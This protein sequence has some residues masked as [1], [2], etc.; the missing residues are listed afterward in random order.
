MAAI[1]LH[2]RGAEGDDLQEICRIAD[3]SRATFYRA[4]RQYEEE[5]AVHI[6]KSKKR[7]RPREY[8][9]AD[10]MYL[11]SLVMRTPTYYLRDFQKKLS[12][13]RFLDLSESTLHRIFKRESF[14]HKKAEKRAAEQDEE[15]VARFIYSIS[16]Y[17]TAQLSYLDESAK[18]ERTYFKLY[19]RAP[20]GMPVEVEAPFVRGDRYT[21]LP[22]MDAHGIYAVK[23]VLGSMDRDLFMDFLEYDVV[24]MDFIA[25]LLCC[26]DSITI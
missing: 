14:S 13:N 1:R 23:V 9:R 2:V 26:I 5:G 12:Q 19:G 11:K 20:I 4:L 3:M 8:V 6:H 24:S 21:L 10:I 7:G 15:E 18:D 25:S 16:R 17:K 22:A